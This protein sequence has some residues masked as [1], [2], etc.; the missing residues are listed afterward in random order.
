MAGR[1]KRI[2]NIQSYINNIDNHTFSG[3]MK[4]GTQPSIGK[5]KYY[6]YNYYQR[7]NQDPNAIKKS[8]DN[9]VFL[10]INSAQTPVP[11]GFRPTTNNNYIYLPDIPNTNGRP[12][13]DKQK[14]RQHFF[15]PYK[16]PI[17]NYNSPYPFNP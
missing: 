17:Y 16:Y 11:A 1:P 8:Y 15:S 6:W 9:M 2:R 3:P 12:I 14:F 7:C 4:T 13:Y 10:N 5:I